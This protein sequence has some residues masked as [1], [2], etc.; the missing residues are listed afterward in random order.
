MAVW[1]SGTSKYSAE[2]GPLSASS[3]SCREMCCPGEDG[4]QLSI[5]W[6]R[7]F[8]YSLLPLLMGAGGPSPGK[9]FLA[10]LGCSAS[11][12]DDTSACFSLVPTFPCTR[13]EQEPETWGYPTNTLYSGY[14]FVPKLFYWF[15]S[16]IM[17]LKRKFNWSLNGGGPVSRHKESLYL[18]HM[19]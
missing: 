16:F 10:N 14:F 18:M 9:P 8:R 5:T 11:I 17:Y 3:T 1:I 7:E 4:G 2:K 13:H 19:V 6:Q 15:V 12:I